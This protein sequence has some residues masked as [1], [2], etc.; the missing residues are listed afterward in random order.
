MLAEMQRY[1]IEYVIVSIIPVL[2]NMRRYRVEYVIVSIVSR[3]VQMK[4]YRIE[5]VIASIISLVIYDLMW[6]SICNHG[7]RLLDG[8]VSGMISN[9]IHYVYG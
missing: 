3:L 4:R 5:Y 1:R 6:D 9:R 2:T 8:T 7:R